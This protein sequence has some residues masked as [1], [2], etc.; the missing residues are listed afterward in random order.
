VK[1]TDYVIKL[2]DYR[3]VRELKGYWSL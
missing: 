3:R 1:T 2:I